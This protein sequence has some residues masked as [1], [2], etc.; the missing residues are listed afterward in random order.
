MSTSPEQRRANLFCG[1]GGPHDA[2]W[3][4]R[5]EKRLGILTDDLALSP[6][7]LS[8]AIKIATDEAD[9]WE[10]AQP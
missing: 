3:L 9:A 1:R 8:A 10:A 5:Y 2:E 7:E 6:E 4:Y